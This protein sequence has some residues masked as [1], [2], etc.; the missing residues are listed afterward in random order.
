MDVDS[1]KCP[2]CGK[3]RVM[4]EQLKYGEESVPVAEPMYQYSYEGEPEYISPRCY[5]CINKAMEVN[6]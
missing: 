6:R 5:D 3:M 1:V 2:I 4:L